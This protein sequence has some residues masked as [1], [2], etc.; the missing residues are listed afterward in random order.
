MSPHILKISHKDLKEERDRLIEHCKKLNTGTEEHKQL[1]K[2]ITHVL[3][4]VSFYRGIIAGLVHRLNRHGFKT[5]IKCD[6]EE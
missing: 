1:A 4:M 3:T 6:E 5:D 2:D